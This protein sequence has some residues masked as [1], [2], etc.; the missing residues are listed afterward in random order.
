MDMDARGCSYL[1]KSGGGGLWSGGV[2]TSALF[3]NLEIIIQ[4]YVL[5]NSVS[6]SRHSFT[7]NT[8]YGFFSNME[9]LSF[10]GKEDKAAWNKQNAAP[11]T[12]SAGCRTRALRNRPVGLAGVR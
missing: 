7:K 4:G 2:H 8:R 9:E 11:L 5:L 3:S 6:L 10:C 1:G 12:C